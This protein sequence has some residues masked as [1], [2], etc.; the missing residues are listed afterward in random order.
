MIS[1]LSFPS[2]CVL[3]IA[4]ATRSCSKEYVEAPHDGGMSPSSRRS[5]ICKRC[6]TS[7]R[8]SQ[9]LMTQGE[10][11]IVYGN[12]HVQPASDQHRLRDAPE[13]T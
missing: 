1:A 10:P 12:E 4:R 9:A 11:G 5:T 8:L 6:M 3:N 2:T 13:R 7:R